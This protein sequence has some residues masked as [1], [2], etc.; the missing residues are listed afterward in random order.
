MPIKGFKRSLQFFGA[1]NPPWLIQIAE[2]VFYCVQATPY[3]LSVLAGK[4]V[5]LPPVANRGFIIAI[6][7]ERN[8]TPKSASPLGVTTGLELSPPAARRNAAL[9]LSM[10][11]IS[12][13]IVVFGLRLSP[14]HH[15]AGFTTAAIHLQLVHQLQQMRQACRR[16]HPSRFFFIL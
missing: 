13:I 14:P 8:A 1:S 10:S 2:P 7:L 3:A 16:V 6:R 9:V 11:M 4:P 12:L 5:F 15:A